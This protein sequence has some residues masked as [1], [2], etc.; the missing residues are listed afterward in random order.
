MIK[1]LAL[2]NDLCSVGRCSLSIQIP[3]VTALQLSACPI[4]TAVLSNHTA[5]PHVSSTGLGAVMEERLE[6]LSENDIH[7]DG[8]L[9]GY[10]GDCTDLRALDAYLEAEKLRNPALRIFL[11]PAMA[12]HGRL[13][14]GMTEEHIEA[15]RAL[16]RKADLICPNL[17][18]AAFLADFD[19]AGLK[20][21]LD[22]C[23]SAATRGMV[24]HA[25]L[26]ELHH[27]TEGQI[28]VTGVEAYPETAEDRATTPEALINV[29]SEA[30]G[31]LR[32]VGHARSGDA[33]PGTGDLF[34]AIV[35]SLCLR[36]EELE[37]ATR[38]AADF[39][40]LCIRHSE[41]EKVPIVY[42][43]QFED[44]LGAL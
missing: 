42:G 2:I 7:F 32:F 36:G 10:L 9:I 19:Y 33:R 21:T 38:R 15:M 35:A 12:D 20:E 3:V 13:Y 34:S 41:E 1:K 37:N 26:S 17:T 11:D 8:I 4:P 40:A 22:R 25:L 29:V 24:M 44:V 27:L 30:D 6:T 28:V 14:R 31:D 39:V 16:C 43:V 18:E 5:F 23:T